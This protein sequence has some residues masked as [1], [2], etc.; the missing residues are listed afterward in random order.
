MS[1]ALTKTLPATPSP[2][3]ASSIELASSPLPGTWRHPR[4]DEIMRRKREATFTDANFR[5]MG[6]NLLAMIISFAA[7]AKLSNYNLSLPATLHFYTHLTLLLLRVLFLYH[8]LT[9]LTPLIKRHDDLSD[10]PLTPTQ[11]ARLGLGPSSAPVTPGSQY[12]TPPRYAR[13]S[14]PRSASGSGSPRG[15]V[16]DSPIGGSGSPLL[17]KALRGDGS[18]GNGAWKGIS[19]NGSFIRMGDSSARR[20]SYGSGSPIGAGGNGL[21]NGGLGMTMGSPSALDLSLENMGKKS[22]GAPGTP[23]PGQGKASV[24]LNNKWLYDRKANRT[25]V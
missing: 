16:I 12:I 7:P 19:R 23:T 4:F 14:T 10:I 22:V 15:R 5:K 21:G 13:S 3:V 11:R 20:W 17:Q 1:T 8:I 24:A 2:N 18:P 25:R 6:Y 9:S